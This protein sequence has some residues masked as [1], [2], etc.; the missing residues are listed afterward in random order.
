MC[1]IGNQIKD[2]ISSVEVSCVIEVKMTEWIEGISWLEWVSGVAGFLVKLLTRFL[3]YIL[4][5]SFG[6]YVVMVVMSPVYSWLSE[7]TEEIVSGREYSFNLKQLFWEIGRGIAISLR[8]MILQLL[9]M[10]VLFFGSFIPLAGLVMPVLTFVS[11]VWIDW[12][13]AVSMFAAL[14]LALLVLWAST[15]AQKKLSGR[16]IQ[17]KINA[18]N[19]LEEY[20]QGI[21]VMKAYNLLG[22]RFTRLRDAFAE[23]R[24]ACIRQEA[25]LGPFVL[26][27]ITLVR[28]GLT[29]MV[30]WEK[31]GDE[32]LCP[33]LR[34]TARTPLFQRCSDG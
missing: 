10:I 27:S 29:M 23:L 8:C 9:V 30:L 34:S 1:A 28:A 20:L 5:I 26:L 25:L 14:P 19:R 7:R 22:D 6:G 4:F 3:Y 13:M 18:G 31:H 15:S 11:L 16:Q 32:A 17:A 2:A 21:R 33:F 12:R 24:R